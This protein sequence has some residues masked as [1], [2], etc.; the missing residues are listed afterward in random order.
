MEL[1]FQKRL[2]N[3]PKIS[4]NCKSL[5]RINK[6]EEM[7][8]RRIENCYLID[9]GYSQSDLKYI[10]RVNQEIMAK[11]YCNQP[12]TST[13]DKAAALDAFS[14]NLQLLRSFPHQTNDK[15]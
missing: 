12:S 4:T 7:K 6:K 2:R 15:T 13:S 9:E 11:D 8:N 1:H 3:L 14:F 10:S 5:T